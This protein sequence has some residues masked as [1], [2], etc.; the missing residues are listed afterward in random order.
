MADYSLF[1]QPVYAGDRL[2]SATVAD[3]D[4]KSLLV[5][6]VELKG[7][8]GLIG[9]DYAWHSLYGHDTSARRRSN[10]RSRSSMTNCTWRRAII[11][12]SSAAS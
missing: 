5:G 8:S 11:T 2:A 7:F 4:G 12:L 1:D 10:S 3:T 9:D 6:V